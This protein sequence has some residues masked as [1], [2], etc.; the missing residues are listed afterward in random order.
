MAALNFPNSPTSGDIFVGTVLN[1]RW[2][3]TVWSPVSNSSTSSF[4]L[5][6]SNTIIGL[7][8]YL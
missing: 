2:D 4:V 5:E 7:S 6:D 3:G 1:W 8:V